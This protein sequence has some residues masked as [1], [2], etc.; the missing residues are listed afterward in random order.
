MPPV[1]DAVDLGTSE[2]QGLIAQSVQ[3]FAEVEM[4]PHVRDWD[5]A[6]HFP[7]AL[8][9]RLGELGLMGVMV[10]ERYGGS[11]MGPR[12]LATVIEELARVDPA[13][14]LSVAA[15]NGLCIGHLMIGANEDQRQ[16]YLPKLATGEWIGCW[17]LTEPQAGSDAAGTRTRAE[18]DEPS[19]Q[20]ILN[21]SKTFNTNGARADLAVIHAVTT[22]EC[23]NKGISA[24]AVESSTAGYRVGRK[25]DK[26]GMRASDTVE[27]VLE[28]C[29]VP[30]EN[31]L[32]ERDRG[33][34]DALKVLDRGR[35]SIGAL[36]VGIG[37]A[38]FDS[39]VAYVHERQQ[40]GRPIGCFEAIRHTLA[41][42]FA[43]VGAARRLVMRAATL[44]ELGKPFKSAASMAKLYASETAMRAA[45]A[46]LQIHG[47][48]GYVKD[49]PVEKYFRDAK[50]CTIGE[51]TSE[52]QRL[53]I[54]RHLLAAI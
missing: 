37:Q 35:I 46:A 41:R 52:I 19:G 4:R 20:W 23:G 45:E 13:V 15:H 22:A 18:F 2:E 11:G 1:I 21:G 32:G 28:D 31:M 14:A 48:Y 29:A 6:Q 10:P 40:F 51:G 30:A 39:A 34:V 47:G 12:E 5:E 54:A 17:G 9:R 43:E 8:L 38:S 16:R 36:S 49:Y 7:D 3:E 53:V 50:L 27:L 25:E 33:F 44:R 42:M 24:F 26:L